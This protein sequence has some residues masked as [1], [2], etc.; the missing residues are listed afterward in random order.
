MKTS[1]GLGRD[2][3]LVDDF[4][5]K[6]PEVQRMLLSKYIQMQHPKPD[7]ECEASPDGSWRVIDNDEILMRERYVNHVDRF[8]L[9]GVIKA[10]LG[11]SIGSTAAFDEAARRRQQIKGGVNNVG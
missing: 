1:F 3:I 7:G 5:N 10:H 9:E 4:D 11:D 8:T 2:E 6:E